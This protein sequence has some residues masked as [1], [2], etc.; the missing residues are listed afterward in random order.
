MLG[1]LSCVNL[2]SDK[3]LPPY[4]KE[5]LLKVPEDIEKLLSVPFQEF[6]ISR[7]WVAEQKAQFDERCL[8]LWNV[9]GAPAAMIYHYAGAERFALWTIDHRDLLLNATAELGRRR[10][11]LVEALAKAGA[12]PVFHTAGY[13][14]FI[15]PLLSPRDLREFIMPYEKQFCWKVHEFGYYVWAHSH[16][17][18]NAFLEDFAAIGVDCLQPLEPG[19][20]GD[21]DWTD[22]KRRIGNRVTLVGNVQTHELMMAPTHEVRELVRQCVRTGKPG[23]RFALS[24]SAE[25]IVAPTITDL[26]RDNLLAYFEVGYEEGRF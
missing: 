15:P 13:E 4:E 10:L 16:G 5:T 25:P 23:G 19:P 22:A 20:M 12:G 21:V 24:P 26:H 6:E 11:Q 14:D 3:Q 1:V 18:V 9:G 17:R 8:I 7:E 2:L